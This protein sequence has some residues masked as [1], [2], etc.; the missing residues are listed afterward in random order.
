MTPEERRAL[1][2]LL[3]GVQVLITLAGG[4]FGLGAPRSDVERIRRQ[5]SQA[6]Q[7][8]EPDDKSRPTL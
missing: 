2:A 6:L 4:Q 7:D 1:A 8:L 3:E 5:V